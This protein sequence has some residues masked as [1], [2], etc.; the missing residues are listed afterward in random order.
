[1]HVRLEYNIDNVAYHQHEF[2]DKSPTSRLTERLGLSLAGPV[3]Q[4]RGL[5]S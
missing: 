4:G 2:L 3:G 5:G 1:M